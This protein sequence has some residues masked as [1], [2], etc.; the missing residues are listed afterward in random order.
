MKK[1]KTF[2]E[3]IL[4]GEKL[5]LYELLPPPRDL[6]IPEIRNSLA[7]FAQTIKKHPIDAINIPEIREETRAGRRNLPELVKIEPRT[8]CRYLQ[9]FGVK[10]VIINRPVAY[11]NWKDQLVWLEETYTKH[12]IKN[13]VFVGGESSKVVYPGPS[14]ID[15]AEQI[16]N[17]HKKKFP[18]ICIG[19]I[20]IPTRKKEGV[21]LFKKSQA[22]IAFFTSQILYEAAS[23][24]KVLKQ[25]MLLCQKHKVK[26]RTVLLSFAPV[27]SKKDIEF[28][29]WL[30]VAMPA[31]TKAILE[32]GW[33][34]MG[35][36]SVEICEKILKD[37]LTSLKKEDISVPIGLN[38]EHI[39][40]HNF[41]LSFHL[42]EKLSASY[43]L[44]DQTR[45]N[46]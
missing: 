44:A 14:V 27:T 4:R 43:S 33:L 45:K 15:A 30:G 19:G 29:Q 10:N 23:T 28:L 13:F 34:G 41:E 12:N 11:S 8:V 26:P 37:I 31:K 36:R 32:K 42:L 5:I 39:S 40:R 20:M 35:F 38:I 22:G 6:S 17:G 2:L 16:T 7:L 46:I 1:N 18:D 25:Y 3:K 9:Q 21:R 24:K